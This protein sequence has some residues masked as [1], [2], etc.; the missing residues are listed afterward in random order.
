MIIPVALVEDGLEGIK[1]GDREDSS[2]L[3]RT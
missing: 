3:G 2:S 1:T